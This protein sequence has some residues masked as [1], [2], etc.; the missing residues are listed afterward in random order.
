MQADQ[1]AP[2]SSKADC[3]VAMLSIPL[4]YNRNESSSMSQGY[5]F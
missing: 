4:Q 3:V 2:A 5:A 1:A